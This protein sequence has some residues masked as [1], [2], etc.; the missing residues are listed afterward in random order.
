M[1][2]PEAVRV[3]EATYGHGLLNDLKDLLPDATLVTMAAPY[4]QVRHDLPAAPAHV[5]FVETM[6]QDALDRV[7]DGLPVTPV[8]V[9]LGG[10]LACDMAK[11]LA[12]KFRR[13]LVLVPTVV[14]VDAFVTR[15]AAARVGRRVRYVGD[16]FPERLLIDFDLIRAAPAY[17]NRAGVGD[18]LSIHTALWDWRF[19]REHYGEEYHDGIARQAAAI[20][21]RVETYAPDLH[22]VTETGVRTLVEGFREEV[23]LCEVWTSSRP[24]EGSEHYLAYCLEALTGRAYLHGALVTLMVLIA[25]RFQDQDWSRPFSIAE[26]IGVPFRP[27]ALGLSREDLAHTLQSV[28]AFVHAERL[29][30]G[31]FHRSPLSRAE[32]A[33]AVDWAFNL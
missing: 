26:R 4:E 10:G 18:L 13:R 1:K 20:L 6:E 3:P 8:V 28:H 24:E 30:P 27:S 16:A 14:S 2:S 22:D 17:L 25:C 12:W 9:G 21:D 15:A 23:R 31:V 5:H 7:C 33:R 11:Y 19:A 29:P 32:V